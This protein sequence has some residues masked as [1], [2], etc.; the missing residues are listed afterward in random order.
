MLVS[1]RHSVIKRF[2][3]AELLLCVRVN[4][5]FS[6]LRIRQL[7]TII[8]ELGNGVFWY[9]LIALLPILF[10]IDAMIASGMMVL[11]GLLSLA[12]YKIIKSITGR[13]RPCS[14][15]SAIQLGAAPL[16]QYSFPSG[17]TLH[18]VSFTIIAVYYFPVLGWVLIPFTVLVA[19]SRVI[20]GL[21]YPTDVAAGALLGGLIAFACLGFI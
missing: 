2:A 7:F 8:S 10:G 9:V 18:A 11:S 21:H 20:L 16:D 1:L 4:N 17:H 15:H 14:I 12:V 19:A 6:H 3:E 5:Y 13:A